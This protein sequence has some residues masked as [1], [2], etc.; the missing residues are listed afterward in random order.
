MRPVFPSGGGGGEYLLILTWKPACKIGCYFWCYFS[1]PIQVNYVSHFSVQYLPLG[2]YVDVK[3]Y[4]VLPNWLISTNL[5][6][7]NCREFHWP[8]STSK[9][10]EQRGSV[11]LHWRRVFGDLT[12]RNFWTAPKQYKH[13]FWTPSC[14][15]HFSCTVA[16]IINIYLKMW[17]LVYGYAA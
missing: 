5:N 10:T 14:N 8:N 2:R 7:K 3:K 4:D 9:V 17:E 6:K 13:L 11:E 12:V 1:L 15:H 16:G